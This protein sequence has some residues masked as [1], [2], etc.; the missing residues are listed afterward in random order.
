MRPDITRINNCSKCGKPLNGIALMYISK[1]LC[2]D[3]AEDKEDVLHCERGCKVVAD[4]L[5][6]GLPNDSKQAHRF[7]VKGQTYEVDKII[8]GGW[9]SDILLKEFPDTRFNTVHFKRKAE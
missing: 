9:S 1:W 4:N 8:V 7:L 3:C 6:N 5:D 2:S